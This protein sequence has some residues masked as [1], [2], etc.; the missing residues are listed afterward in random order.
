MKLD[1]IVS[2]IRPLV[3]DAQEKAWKRWDSLTKPRKSLGRLEEI[4][5]QLAGIRGD[6][7]PKINKKAIVIM[8]GDHGIVKRGVSAYP[9]E[10]TVQ[11][12]RN[13]LNG[14]AGINAIAS[15]ANAEVFVVDVGIAHPV[16]FNHPSFRN[17]NVRHGTNDFSQE[18]AMTRDEAIKCIEVGIQMAEE[19]DKMKIDIVG[20]GEMGIGNTTPSTAILSVFAKDVSLDSIVGAGTGLD[21]EGIKK[22]RTVISEAIRLHKPNPNDPIDVLEKVGGLEIGAIAGLVI[23]CAYL[24]KPVVIDGFISTV[25]ALLA[26]KIT[27]DVLPY[28][29]PS[30]LSQEPG[31]KIALDQ[32]GLRSMLTLD[33]RLGEGTGSAIG[34]IIIDCALNAYYNMLTFEEAG[35]SKGE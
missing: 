13:F 33:M 20:T 28:I 4:V 31:H 29:I 21:K 1:E 3:E 27:P 14:G 22:K 32:M 30:H 18:P 23:G 2:N 9:Q 24:R 7:S 35:V 11:M 8:V 26:Y 34:M 25:G 12:V 17:Y 19:L 6:P 10:V 15:R 5:V 16:E